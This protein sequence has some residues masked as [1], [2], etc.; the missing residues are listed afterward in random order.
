MESHDLAKNSEVVG[1]GSPEMLWD[2]YLNDSL[3]QNCF[4]I[5]TKEIQKYSVI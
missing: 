5:S 4:S 3:V 1:L 2:I